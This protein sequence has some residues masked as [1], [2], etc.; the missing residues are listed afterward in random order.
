MADNPE[1]ILDDEDQQQDEVLEIEEEALDD[2]VQDTDDGGA[3]VTL[4]EDDNEPSERGF[5][6][7]LVDTLDQQ[8]LQDIASQF[9]KLIEYDKECRKPRDEQYTEAIQ[10]TG[11]GKEAPGGATFPGASRAVHPMLMKAS[12][13]FGSR[14]IAELFPSNGPVK[15]FIPGQP[16]AEQSRKAKRKVSYMNWQCIKQMPELR[17]VL[18][19]AVSQLPL[20]GSQYLGLKYDQKR[21]RPVPSFIP[22]D[23][24]YIPFAADSFYTAE[25]LTVVEH[26]TEME[27]KARVK[28]GIYRDSAGGFV[29]SMLP[30]QSKAAQASDKVEGKQSNWYNEDGLRDIYHVMCFLDVEDYEEQP[31]LIDICSVSHEVLSVVRNWEPDEE[32]EEGITEI[33]RQEPMYWIIDLGFIPW[34]GPYHIGL[35]QLIGSL[36]GAATGALRALLDSAHIQNFPALAKLKGANFSGQST[37][38]NTTS[39]TE[40]EGGVG[41]DA[42]IRKLLMAIPY[43]QTSPVLLNLLSFVV[44]EGSEVVRTILDRLGDVSTNA[45]VGTTLAMIEQAMKVFNAIHLRLVGSMS[46]FIQVLQRINRLYLTDA[47]IKKQ[48]GRQLAFAKDFDNPEDVIPTADPEIFSDVQR[49][50]QVQL[51]AQRAQGNPLYDPRKVEEM[52]L[53][54]ARIPDATSLLVK[55][56]KPDEMNAVNENLAMVMGRPVAAFPEQDHLGHIQVLLDFLGSPMFG[57]SSLIAPGFIPAALNHLR[58]HMVMWYVDANVRA[59]EE[60]TKTSIKTLMKTKDPD[61]RIEMDK[62]LASISPDVIAAAMRVFEKIPAAIQKAQ[63]VLQQLAPPPPPPMDPS[64]AALQAKQMDVSIAEKKAQLEAQK[65]TQNNQINMQKEQLKQEAEDRR[66]KAEIDAKMIMNRE[67]NM[68]ALTIAQGEM[69]SGERVALSTGTGINPGS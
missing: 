54:R 65:V 66:T 36:S 25:R 57:Q 40:I 41:A 14:T 12:I 11:L 38:L 27:F 60:S 63:E 43:N 17:M 58:D 32:W 29:T 68:T 8:Q 50:G 51:V 5:Y 9:L 30:E 48:C 55:E 33:D 52:I 6:D 69:D 64:T 62:T 53:S 19:Q 45:P 10:R 7:N 24:V 37:E 22:I 31:Y 28:A 47:D 15:D 39:I 61:T 3:V 26:I 49:W 4:D 23:D 56:A 16:T 13:D 2:E 20:G 44:Q 59:L 67:D 18:E 46:R 42:D 1:D 21:K 34:R 35:G